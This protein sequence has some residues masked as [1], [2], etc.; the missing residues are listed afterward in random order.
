MFYSFVGELL[1]SCCCFFFFFFLNK[2]PLTVWKYLMNLGKESP[3]N[4]AN[5][6]QLKINSLNLNSFSVKD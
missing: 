6:H 4:A 1:N 2:S 5:S 3:Q